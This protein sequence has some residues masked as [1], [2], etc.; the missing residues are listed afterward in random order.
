MRPVVWS[1][2]ARRNYFEI[3]RYIA[4]DNPVAAQKVV[5]AIEKAGEGLGKF[6]TG[7]PGRV[8]GT[9]EKPVPR[10]PYIIV[11]SLTVRA[12]Q[13]VIA[14]LRIIHTARDWRPEEWPQ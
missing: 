7:K 14:I 10:L 13:E 1:D 6:P 12:G 3:L 2:A 11:Y 8:S 4:E 5:S 9:Y